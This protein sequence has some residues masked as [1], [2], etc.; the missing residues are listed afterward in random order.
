MAAPDKT[1]A[2]MRGLV[3]AGSTRASKL[4]CAQAVGGVEAVR[5]PERCEVPC[6]TLLW[7]IR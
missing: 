2:I 6:R 1:V 3:V 7:P 5:S 4:A